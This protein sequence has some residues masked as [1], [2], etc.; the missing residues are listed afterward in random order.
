MPQ[1]TR[2]PAEVVDGE[3]IVKRSDLTEVFSHHRRSA[4]CRA[5]GAVRRILALSFSH[6]ANFDFRDLRLKCKVGNDTPNLAF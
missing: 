4:R 2:P 1:G 6:W 5:G 3:L